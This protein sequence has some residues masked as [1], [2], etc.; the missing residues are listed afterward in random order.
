MHR[1]TSQKGIEIIKSFESFSAVPYVCPAGRQTIGYGHV[2]LSGEHYKTLSLE[3]GENLLR[4][5]LLAVERAVLRNINVPLGD[6]QFDALVSLT[7][8]I[9]SGALQRSTLRQKINYDSGMNEIRQEFMK[10]IYARGRVLSGLVRR[11][12]LESELYVC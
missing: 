12:R 10:W 8:N 2:I 7:F 11:R 5:D 6:A 9:G 3:D 4:K 1:F